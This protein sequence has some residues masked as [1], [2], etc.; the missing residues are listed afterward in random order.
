VERKVLM[1][2]FILGLIL[3][4]G[5]HVTTVTPS[6]HRLCSARLPGQAWRGVVALLS[7]LGVVLICVGWHSVPNHALFA[8]SAWVISAAPV[9]VSVALILFVI[10][11]ANLNSHIRQQQRH[12]MVIGATIWAATHLLAN[13]T[14]RETV[15]FGSF[16]LFAVY[17]L[18]VLFASGKRANFQA[19]L[20]WDVIGVLLGLFVAIGV[21][22]SHKLLFGVAVF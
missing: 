6:L 13:G 16:L 1:N 7:L 8:P 20:K 10:G 22:H 21:M 5:I 18:V 2:L 17:A 12:P 19:S 15:L 9:L 14:W 3:F 4:F 11:G